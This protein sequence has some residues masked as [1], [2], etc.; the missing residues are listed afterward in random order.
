MRD[1]KEDERESPADQ[2]IDTGLEGQGE[3]VE[4]ESFRG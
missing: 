4:C 3:R 2:L 1:Q